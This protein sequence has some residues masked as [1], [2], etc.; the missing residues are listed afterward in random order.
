[1]FNFLYCFDNNYNIPAFCSIYS[2]LE[3][4]DQKINI[5]I[6]HKT[7]KDDKEFPKAI[8]EHK[9]IGEL[10]I[11]S[12]KTDNLHFPNIDGAHISE[13]TYYRLL[14]EDYIQKSL[15]KLIYLDCDVV[16]VNNPLEKLEVILNE[17]KDSESIVGVLPEPGMFDYANNNYNLK[18]NYFNAGVMIIDFKK[19]RDEKP[20]NI[21]LQIINDYDA[22]LKYWDQDVL[23]IFFNNKYKPISTSLNFKVDMEIFEK[24]QLNKE[25][26]NVNF[27]HYSGKFKPWS[28]RGALNNNSEYF[29]EIYR[30]LFVK[31]YY[32]LFNYKKNALKDLLMGFYTFSIFKTLY[33]WHFIYIA[34]RKIIKI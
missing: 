23:N 29:Q 6:M 8:T 31:K 17:V 25:Y 27:L 2:L 18:N 33:P 1:M 9:N 19:W 32:F 28:V 21:F 5:N 24:M 13:A 10:N 20:K 26:S 16:C 7:M 11:Y 15:E 14:I 4:V 12:V 3:N 34:I 30:K 22:K